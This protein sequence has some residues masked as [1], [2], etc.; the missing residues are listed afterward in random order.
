[1][2][3]ILFTRYAL[4]DRIYVVFGSLNRIPLQNQGENMAT[5]VGTIIAINEEEYEITHDFEEMLILTRNNHY[6]LHFPSLNN[7]LFPCGKVKC[8]SKVT[9]QS[10][11]GISFNGIT[12]P[13]CG[14]EILSYDTKDFFIK[15]S[16]RD[17]TFRTKK[18]G[19]LLA[20]VLK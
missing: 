10:N 6:W 13:I 15:I 2:L 17:L 16:T 19:E 12:F 8:F 14:Y 9:K 18:S 20:V 3:Y 4:W 7:A 1:L 5:K 11:G